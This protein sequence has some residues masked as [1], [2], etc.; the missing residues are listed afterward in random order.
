MSSRSCRVPKAPQAPGEVSADLGAESS[1]VDLVAAAIRADTADLDSYHRVL[2]ST[3]SGLL[4]VGMVEVDRERSMKDRMAGREGQATS[5]RIRLGD[6]TLELAS[7]HGGLVA[8]SAREVRGVVISRQ[9][10]SVAEWTQLLA[11][12]LAKLAAQSAE[13]RSALAK[14]LGE[15]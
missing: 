5:I 11:Q 10:I 4:P 8:T 1:V 9:E 3:V 13:A 12:H 15:S 2:S 6:L 14:L 7:R